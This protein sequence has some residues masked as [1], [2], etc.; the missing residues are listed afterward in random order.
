MALKYTIFWSVRCDISTCQQETAHILDAG[1]CTDE[2]ESK[3]WVTP[4]G[5]H[6]YCPTHAN[7]EEAQA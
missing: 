4:D 7:S 5:L 1:R 6:W 2:S 3:G